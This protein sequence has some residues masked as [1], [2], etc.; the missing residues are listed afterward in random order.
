M[1]LK[2]SET[3]Q[4]D[5]LGFMEHWC[6]QQDET[7]QPQ[8]PLMLFPASLSIGFAFI[9]D[10]VNFSDK[11]KVIW[12][13]RTICEFE[14]KI[15]DEV[16]DIVMSRKL[17]LDV[18]AFNSSQE[19]SLAIDGLHEDLMHDVVDWFNERFHEEFS[20]KDVKKSTLLFKMVLIGMA[21]M[22]FSF[23]KL[24]TLA[25]DDR[26]FGSD[27]LACWTKATL[28]FHELIVSVKD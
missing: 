10:A 6:E 17:A 23:T 8:L 16:K 19:A 24:M 21:M 25:P 20:D 27:L 7:I 14:G 13:L 5:V 18:S 28:Y 22:E 12:V 15:L 11:A 4:L 3:I 26:D 1:N 9:E 2:N